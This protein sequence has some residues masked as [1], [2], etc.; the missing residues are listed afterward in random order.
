[1]LRINPHV[2]KPK[3]S[4]FGKQQNRHFK[5]EIEFIFIRPKGKGNPRSSLRGL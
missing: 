4:S 3:K 5:Q 2:D 1:M